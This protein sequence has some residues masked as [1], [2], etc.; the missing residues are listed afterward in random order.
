MIGFLIDMTELG[1]VPHPLVRLGIRRLCGQ[2]LTALAESVGKEPQFIE[3]YV[4]SLRHSPVAVATDVANQQHYEVPAAFFARC[5]GKQRKYSCAFFPENVHSLDEAETLALNLTMERADIHDGMRILELGCGWGSL[6]LAMAAR[7][8]GARITAISNSSSQREFIE[9]E[10]RA[11]GLTNT[12]VLTRDMASFDAADVEPGGFDRVVS[13]EMFEHLRNYEEVLARIKTWLVPG[14][15]LFVHIFTHRNFPYLFEADGD[16]NWMGKYFF[17]GGQ[18]PSHNLLK[19]FQKDLQLESEWAWD[20]THYQKTA[21]AWL[22]NL[23]ANKQEILR[24]FTGVYG[25]AEAVR[26]LNRWRIF[27]LSVSELFGFRSGSE[28]G[29]SHYLFTK[30]KEGQ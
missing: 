29:V 19:C 10:L 15:K 8:P 11:R 1:F 23:E 30:Q 21:E 28:W 16:H 13:V 25:S 14:G 24:L 22:R 26:W 2:R 6:T 27:F 12:T 9:N 4:D 17:T 20:G 18:M 3:R 5:L 7:F